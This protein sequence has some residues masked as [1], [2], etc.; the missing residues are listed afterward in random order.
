MSSP[1]TTPL[2]LAEV[3]REVDHYQEEVVSST[4]APPAEVTTAASDDYD[5]V[6]DNPDVTS[7]P[8]STPE[9]DV[10]A[11]D[12]NPDNDSATTMSLAPSSFYSEDETA[13]SSYD[14]YGKIIRRTIW[15]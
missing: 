13:T 15:S 6:D 11:E 8:T 7:T 14:D 5:F 1:P 3:S 2:G 4:V 10:T 9:V 12:A